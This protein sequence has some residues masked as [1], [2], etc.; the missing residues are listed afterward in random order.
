MIWT[1][2]HCLRS[3]DFVLVCFWGTTLPVLA[4]SFTAR[5]Y[6]CVKTNW[7]RHPVQQEC[8]KSHFPS[9]RCNWW[10]GVRF[11]SRQGTQ[12]KIYMRK[13]MFAETLALPHRTDAPLSH[14]CACS[15]MARDPFLSTRLSLVGSWDHTRETVFIL[16]TVIKVA[17]SSGN[18]IAQFF[19]AFQNLFSSREHLTNDPCDFAQKN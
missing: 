9:W 16:K 13:Q 11:M 6:G 18:K 2:P 7:G 1:G 19:V 5:K 3:E 17:P 10:I 12:W 4:R 8:Q 15:R 14:P